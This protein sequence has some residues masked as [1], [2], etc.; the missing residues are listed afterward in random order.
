VHPVEPSLKFPYAYGTALYRQHRK[1]ENPFAKLKDWRR[2][3][4]HD[5][6]CDHILFGN[7]HRSLRHR[8]ALINES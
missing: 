8:L 1:M 7:L 4:E 2:I 3:A 5:D 6:R